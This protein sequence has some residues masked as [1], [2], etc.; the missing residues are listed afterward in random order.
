LVL[1]LGNF[2]EFID[3]GRGLDCMYVDGKE[4]E[5][6]SYWWSYLYYS[7]GNKTEAP[8]RNQIVDQTQHQ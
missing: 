7:D 5:V 2:Q 6:T 8:F 1:I 4:V 3:A